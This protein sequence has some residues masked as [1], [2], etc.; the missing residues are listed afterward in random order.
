MNAVGIDVSKG[1][2]KVTVIQPFGKVVRKPFD[3]M[4][5]STELKELAEFIRSLEGEARVVVEHTGKYSE[6]IAKALCDAGIFVCMVNAKLVH[7]YGGDTIRR[8]KTDRIDALKIAKYCLDKWENL[9][10]YTPADESRKMLKTYNRQL[11]EYMKLKIM[12]HN[13]LIALLDQIFPGVNN[14]FSSPARE[15]DGHEKWLDFI[16]GF[17]HSECVS[18][19]SQQSFLNK[20]EKW[21]RKNGFNFSE[22]KAG[23]IYQTAISCF[24]TLPNNDFTKTLILQAVAQLTGLCETIALLKREMNKIAS[25]L[26]EYNIVLEMHGVGKTL[27]PQLIAEIGDI[28]NFLKRSSLT[29]FAGIEPPEN[30][31]GSYN[32]HSRR[33][34]KQGSPHL[35]KTLFQVMSCVLQLSHDNEPTFQFLDKKRSEGK[36]YK[37]YMIAGANKFLR[38]YYARV[39]ECFDK[40]EA[41]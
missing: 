9:K 29:R 40:S 37:V 7:D 27:A 11:S 41:A 18:S 8:D 3:V 36:P 14:L 4:H 16:A 10:H 5:T 1:K 38:I 26:P 25:S 20:Y 12:L 39:K 22:S 28:R 21:C 33:I 23:V 32:Q 31:S 34:S 6:P 13:N 17:W 30:Q 2:S 15:S 19:L 24:V 35:R